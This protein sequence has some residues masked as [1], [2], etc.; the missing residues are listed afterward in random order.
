[1]KKEFE[2]RIIKLWLDDTKQ[3]AE[4]L[5]LVQQEFEECQSKWNEWRKTTWF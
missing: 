5:R 1:M 2:G 3:S 4:A